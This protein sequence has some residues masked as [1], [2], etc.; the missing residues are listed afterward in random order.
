MD[1]NKKTANVA[2]AAEWAQRMSEQLGIPTCHALEA[3]LGAGDPSNIAEWHDWGK[4]LMKW[5]DKAEGRLESLTEQVNSLT[6]AVQKLQ[7]SRVE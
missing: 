2:E 1:V 7:N 4:C 3:I 5:M 6:L